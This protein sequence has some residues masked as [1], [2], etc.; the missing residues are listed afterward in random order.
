M[1]LP[2]TSG[3]PA[4]NEITSSEALGTATALREG[5]H[6]LRNAVQGPAANA[7]SVFQRRKPEEIRGIIY[8]TQGQ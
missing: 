6:A 5:P 2:E 4:L 1:S 3:A 7:R 8:F